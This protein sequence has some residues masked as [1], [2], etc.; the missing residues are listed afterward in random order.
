MGRVFHTSSAAEKSGGVEPSCLISSS[1]GAGVV[2]GAGGGGGGGAA[3]A[4]DASESNAHPFSKTKVRG[5]VTLLKFAQVRLF[6][7]VILAGYCVAMEVSVTS[8]VR[9]LVLVRH[10]QKRLV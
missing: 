8:S 9:W 1:G 5:A 2:A 10:K 7:C 3:T 6:V 4:G